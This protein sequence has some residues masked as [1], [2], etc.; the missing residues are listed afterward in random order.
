MDFFENF[1]LKQN[2]FFW[3]GGGGVVAV[4]NV[5]FDTQRRSFSLFLFLRNV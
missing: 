3:R 4:G 5:V 2:F 1:L